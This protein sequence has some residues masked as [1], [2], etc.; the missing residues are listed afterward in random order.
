MPRQEASHQHDKIAYLT[1]S[2]SGYGWT[3]LPDQNSFCF[4]SSA[5]V[6]KRTHS[7]ATENADE[8]IGPTPKPRKIA[9]I[10]GGISGMGAAYKMSKS[11][12]VV[13][14][15]AEARLAAMPALFWRDA[16]APARRHGFYRI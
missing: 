7:K 11:D 13:L 16:R 6:A 15:E 3:V 8:Y 9:V 14:F 1:V 12:H 4:L 10:G 2:Y 5:F